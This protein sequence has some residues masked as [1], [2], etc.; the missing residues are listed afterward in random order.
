MISPNYQWRYK[1]DKTICQLTCKPTL[2]WHHQPTNIVINKARQYVNLL[3]KQLFDDVIN[4]TRQFAINKAKQYVNLLA[5]QLSDDVI[6]KTLS[7]VQTERF[8][9]TIGRWGI[10]HCKQIKRDRF[11]TCP[12]A[13]AKTPFGFQ[14]CKRKG[15]KKCMIKK[16]LKK[17][18][19][20]C[21]KV[22]KQ[23]QRIVQKVWTKIMTRTDQ[24]LLGLTKEW[25][26]DQ[27][28]NQWMAV[29]KSGKAGVKLTN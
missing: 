18:S 2:K 3:A 26:M 9:W 13:Y 25:L 16:V 14:N 23:R 15:V 28:I 24:D 8:N 4:K 1:Q 5:N 29:Y 6:V 22:S 21:Q 11:T 12:K 7:L 27:L 20:M 17:C 19:K 10:R